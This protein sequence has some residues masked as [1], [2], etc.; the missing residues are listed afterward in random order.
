MVF[1]CGLHFVGELLF[2]EGFRSRV[3]DEFL[4]GD[5]FDFSKHGPFIAAAERDCDA[6]GSGASGPADAVN[7]VF[8]FGRQVEIHDVGD[9]FDVQSSSGDVRRDEDRGL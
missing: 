6:F 1:L 7:V 2:R 3:D 5:R 9:I 4:V 8:D